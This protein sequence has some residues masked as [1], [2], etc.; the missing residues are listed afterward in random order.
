LSLAGTRIDCPF[1]GSFSNVLT[2]ENITGLE[3]EGK[4]WLNAEQI[5]STFPVAL[6]KNDS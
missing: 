5:L 2:K 3:D 6:L 1:A 4:T